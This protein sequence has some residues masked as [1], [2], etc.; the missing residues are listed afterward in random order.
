MQTISKYANY[1]HQSKLSPQAK[2]NGKSNY[3]SL[4]PE[5]TRQI[6]FIGKT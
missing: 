3:H 6:V 5:A 4:P 1:I 2:Q